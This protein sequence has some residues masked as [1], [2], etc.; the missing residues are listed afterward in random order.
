MQPWE[1]GRLNTVERV[2]LAQ[3]IAGEP[4]KTARHLNDLLRLLP[5]NVDRDL[6]LFNVG[7]ARPVDLDQR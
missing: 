5:P 1:Y 7:G 2:L 4:D 3:R 6:F